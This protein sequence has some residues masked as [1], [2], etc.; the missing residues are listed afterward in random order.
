MAL[1]VCYNEPEVIRKMK[2]KGLKRVWL[3][4]AA[5]A[6]A[7][8][9]MVA[10]F[11]LAVV[12]STRN[13][14]VPRQEEIRI[15]KADC[16]LVLGCEVRRDG[17]PSLMLQERLDCAVRLFE[18]GLSDRILMSGDHSKNG[19]NEVKTMKQTAVDA[20]INPDCILMDHAGVSTYDSLCRAA[21]IFG[22]E[23]VVIVTQQYHLYRAL[24]I[25]RQF[26]LEAYGV[27]CD[28]MTYRGQWKREIREI[29]ARDKDF[30]KCLI[31]PDASVM[32]EKI[33]INSPGWVT[34][35]GISFGQKK[36]A[37]S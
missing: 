8:A 15:E 2:R 17:S 36:T 18:N 4:L 23:K 29:A 25:A 35:D 33:P 14:V 30:L 31:L 32:G 16:I 10:A 11:D 3:C 26:G 12:W 27:A 20:G 21:K 22:A 9:V 24:Y 28:Q 19:Y 37:A 34:D 6:L 1:G 5:F 13:S 7:G